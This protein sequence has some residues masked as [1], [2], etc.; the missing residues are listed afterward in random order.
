MKT[1]RLDRLISTCTGLSRSDAKTM[2]KKGL[3]SVNGNGIKRPEQKVNPLQDSVIF[4]GAPIEY[5]EHTYVMLHKPAGVITATKD[6]EHKTVMD[7]VEK[8]YKKLSPVGRLDKDTEG[9]LLLTD[10]GNLAHRLLSPAKGVKKCYEA[11][12]DVEAGEREKKMFEEGLDIGD[13][14]KTLPAQLKTDDKDATKVYITIQEGR[15]HQVKRMVEA[16]G[17]KVLYLKRLSMGSLYLDDSLGKGNF[18]EL[19][20]EEIQGLMNDVGL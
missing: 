3:V 5:R 20:K 16:I 15:Y 2:I 11:L 19:T 4:E 10:D 12:L 14:K 17:G 1:M 18:R 9:L 6:A 13:E 8:R 7:L